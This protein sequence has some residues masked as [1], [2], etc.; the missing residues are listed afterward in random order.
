MKQTPIKLNVQQET[1]SKNTSIPLVQY[2]SSESD[3]EKEDKEETKQ[4]PKNIETKTNVKIDN[5]DDKYQ[6]QEEEDQESSENEEP[7]VESSQKP[8]Q[9]KKSKK[10]CKF[11]S[12]GRCRDG[13]ECRFSHDTV[14][15]FFFFFF[16]ELS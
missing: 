3:E 2:S 1:E 11:F 12:K 9:K 4:T 5:N 16:Y 14:R 8:V 13:T 10:M 7:V 15:F 6:E